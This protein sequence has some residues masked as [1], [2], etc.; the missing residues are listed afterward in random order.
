MAFC[1]RT[2]HFTVYISPEQQKL[3]LQAMD[4]KHWTPWDNCIDHVV[5]ALIA[6]DYPLP[7]GKRSFVKLGSRISCPYLFRCWIED[8]KENIPSDFLLRD[9]DRTVPYNFPVNENKAYCEWHK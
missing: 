2:R 3:A 1:K 7:D 8:Q 6:I 5:D 9:V 4:R